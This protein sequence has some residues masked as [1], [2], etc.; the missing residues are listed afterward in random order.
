MVVLQVFRRS[1]A[2]TDDALILPADTRILLDGRDF[3]SVKY[4]FASSS[5]TSPGGAGRSVGFCQFQHAD[6]LN[7]HFHRVVQVVN[8]STLFILDPDW[9]L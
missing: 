6:K 5:I 2:Y 8:S 3:F 7:L 9:S 4:E 1:K